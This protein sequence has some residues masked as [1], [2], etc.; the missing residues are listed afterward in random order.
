MLSRFIL[1]HQQDYQY[2]VDLWFI[3]V[4]I[5]TLTTVPSGP[6]SPAYEQ[7]WKLRSVP[8]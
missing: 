3:T 7:I 8:L 1:Q 5:Q 6:N 2:L 4:T